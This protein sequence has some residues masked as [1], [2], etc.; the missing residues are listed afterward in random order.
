MLTGNRESTS[1]YKLCK[2]IFFFNII[3]KTFNFEEVA[4][5]IVVDT[6]GDTVIELRFS[7]FRV[8]DSFNPKKL[9]IVA[10]GRLQICFSVSNL[11]ASSIPLNKVVRRT[12][13]VL[14]QLD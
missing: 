7:P 11:I 10:S 5:K 1:V 12:D 14:N 2:D 6:Y 9:A 13:G 8:S 3:V 4:A